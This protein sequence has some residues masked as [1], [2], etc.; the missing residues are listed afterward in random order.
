MLLR[1]LYQCFLKLQECR[2]C[3]QHQKDTISVPRQQSQFEARS[4][5]K[6]CLAA[7]SRKRIPKPNGMKNIT[8]TYT[9]PQKGRKLT[10]SN[11]ASGL[12]SWS[13]SCEYISSSAVKAVLQLKLSRR[14]QRVDHGA[15]VLEH[16]HPI[17]R[18][19]N[20]VSWDG[21]PCLQVLFKLF[22]HLFTHCLVG[23]CWFYPSNSQRWL[24]RAMN[25][26]H[27]ARCTGWLPTHWLVMF[28]PLIA[29]PIPAT[30]FSFFLGCSNSHRPK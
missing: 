15:K 30:V 3:S 26:W 1:A 21:I 6:A 9:D 19:T 29:P 7:T 28:S 10:G 8:L 11:R 20:H 4:Q 14:M 17:P 25:I 24:T 18:K 5:E 2:H 27:S 13:L 22:P 23:I 16:T 12:M